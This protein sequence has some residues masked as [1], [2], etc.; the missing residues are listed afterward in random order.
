APRL[1]GSLTRLAFTITMLGRRL[2]VEV[3]AT[4]A[5]YQIMAG[6]D[7][8]DVWHHGERVSVGSDAAVSLPIPPKPAGPRPQQ[9]PGC[10][11]RG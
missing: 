3:G 2:R 10:E 4:S 5:S 1:P 11:P 8:L 9:P 7:P 6:G